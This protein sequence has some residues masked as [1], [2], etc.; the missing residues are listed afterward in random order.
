M[1]KENKVVELKDEELEKVSGGD[2]TSAN[3]VGYN[4]SATNVGPLNN[5]EVYG[6]LFVG[7]NNN[8]KQ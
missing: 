3:V 4:G 1:S 2:V 6:V 5:N 8:K 7:D